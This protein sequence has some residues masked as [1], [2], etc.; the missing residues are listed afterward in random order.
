[1]KQ[2]AVTVRFLTPAFLG[3]AAQQGAWR[4][5]PFKAQ[6]RYWWRFVYAAERRFEVDVRRMQQEEGA[7]FG[8]ASG[9]SGHA[10]KVRMRLDKWRDGQLNSLGKVDIFKEVYLGYGPVT[11]RGLKTP[12]AI[13][14]NEE[15]RLK[16]SFAAGVDEKQMAQV[17]QAL[18]LMH[19]FGQAGG[20]SR[21][22]WG[23]Y[24]L[25]GWR[26]D[27]GMDAF[28][29]DWRDAL[30]LDWPHAI[31]SDGQPLIWRTEAKKD[32]RQLIGE[33]AQLRRALNRLAKERGLRHLMNYPVKGRKKPGVKRMPNT[34][35][36]KAMLDEQG[37]LYGRI[38]HTPCA[39]R[40]VENQDAQRLWA[41]IHQA[42]DTRYQR[43]KV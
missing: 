32:W 16:L 17:S 43:E 31:G 29:R 40:T 22:G 35:R 28:M 11:N 26:Q 20:R 19:H 39:P 14:A 15:A 5:P 24:V 34:L 8:A 7:L 9:A 6:L 41:M 27:I 2:I 13:D 37:H 4:V 30:A 1:M 21:N 38:L 42:L 23:S 33:F 18:G 36:F 10:S 3:D 12:P 25:E